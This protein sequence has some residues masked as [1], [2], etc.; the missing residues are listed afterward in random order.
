[1]FKEMRHGSSKIYSGTILNIFWLK[2][3]T[4]SFLLIILFYSDYKSIEFKVIIYTT[5][6]FEIRFLMF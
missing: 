4:Y 6:E 5:E 1:M 2:S 3:K